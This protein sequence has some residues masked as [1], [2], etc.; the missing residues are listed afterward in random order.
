MEQPMIDVLAQLNEKEREDFSSWF[1]GLTQKERKSVASVLARTSV[2][3]VRTILGIP[4][5][6]RISMFLVEMNPLEE[7]AANA[8]RRRQRLSD[9]NKKLRK[10]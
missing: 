5:E 2:E 4:A 6:N 8:K 9:F 1:A 10:G 3:R 7:M